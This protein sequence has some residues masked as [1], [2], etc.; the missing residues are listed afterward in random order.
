[1]EV[2]M[3][4]LAITA[5]ASLIAVFPAVSQAQF[6]NATQTTNGVFGSKQIGGVNSST[7]GTAFGGNSGGFGQSS[8]GGFGST[9][10]GGM[11]AQQ[12]GR[13][14]ATSQSGSGAYGSGG[15]GST[16]Y[17]STGMGGMNQMNR[18]GMSQLGGMFGQQ[19]GLGQQFGRQNQMNQFGQN[20]QGNQQRK[21]IR[22]PIRMGFKN[23]LAA[24]NQATAALSARYSRLP[25]L[26]LKS[27]V[28][29]KM[30]G[31]TAVLRGQ[32][33]SEYVRDLAERLA[34]LEP[35]IG[36]V[37]NVLEVVPEDAPQETIP[38]PAA[39]SK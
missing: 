19:G 4:I 14:M 31:R 32:V 26:Q 10:I 18:G 30:E 36:E 17:G 2:D 37:R 25:S 22:V 12:V 35:G 8:G 6:G 13:N 20:G 11:Q 39:G 29:V 9:G 5:V 7:A 1:M 34:L 28:T 27:P 16:G 23:S 38:T 15:Y 33:A 24:S 3:R 21:Q